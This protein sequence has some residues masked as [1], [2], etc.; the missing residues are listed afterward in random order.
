MLPEEIK[1]VSFHN[2]SHILPASLNAESFEMVSWRTQLFSFRS[3]S[4]QKHPE[5]N[6]EA[7]IKRN[8]IFFIKAKMPRILYTLININS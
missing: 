1:F 7:K 5:L 3:A 8:N 2:E 6:L 4:T